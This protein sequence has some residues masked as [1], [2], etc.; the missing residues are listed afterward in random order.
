MKEGLLHYRS[1]GTWL[2]AV[3]KSL[4]FDNENSLDY[5]VYIT[6][7]AVYNAPARA[8]EM[9]SVP[10]R[11]GAFP[12]DQGRFENISV[13]Y[14]AGAFGETQT[15]FASNIMRFRNV[16][17]S[18][19]RYVRL[20]DD[21]NTDE[22][23]LGMYRSGL[24]TKPV[25]MSRAGEFDITFDCKPQRFL[26]SGETPQT[27]SDW[28]DVETETG[29]IVTIDADEKTG[30]KDL[31][32]DIEPIQ[33]LH[34]YTKPWA[35]GNGKN[36]LPQTR[37]T[38]TVNGVTF[39][40]NSDGSVTANGT[41][42][43]GGASFYPDVNTNTSIDNGDYIVTGCPTGGGN[44]TYRIWCDNRNSAGTSTISTTNDAGSG[45][46]LSV[47]E[48]KIRFYIF[49]TAGYTANNLVFKPMFRLASETDASYEPYSN[50]CPI[51]GHTDVVV[52]R[53]G[54]NLL[55]P[56]LLINASLNTASGIITPGTSN[57]V[58]VNKMH[59]P[60]N[61]QLTVSVQSPYQ[62]GSACVYD[63]SGNYLQ[64]IVLSAW[65]DGSYTFSIPN[66]AYYFATNF[67]KSDNANISPSDLDVQIEYGLTATTYE[68]YNGDTYTTALG[69]TVYGGTLDDTTGVLTID[70]AIVTYDGSDDEVWTYYS[71]AQGNMFRIWQNDREQGELNAV[72]AISNRFKLVANADRTNGTMSSPANNP[73]TT[74]IDFIYDACTTEAQWRTWLGSNN[75]QVVYPLATPTTVQLTAEE[76]DLLLGQNNIWASSGDVTVEYGE[77]PFT[78]PTLFASN[79]LI[80]VTGIGTLTVGDTSIV[81]TGTASQVVYIDCESKEIYKINGGVITPAGSLVSF[82]TPDFPQLKPGINK[83]VKGTGITDVEITPRWWRI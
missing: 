78:N 13:K 7:E 64:T 69:T 52:S 36:K 37:T 83:V 22:F 82:S 38:Q 72:G 5:G 29:D 2:M 4:T 26:V 76:I 31:T 68:A 23:R 6:G 70:K 80:K 21:Y 39:T 9:V 74:I 1:R 25:S 71:V 32:A 46:N 40:V 8:M 10:G 67:R 30:L 62:I 45:A 65:T 35:P 58:V 79:P 12:L 81:I 75:V 28:S 16:L 50:I 34:G 47:T 49:I 55:D 56:T 63:G 61:T 41:A 18:R 73:T 66:G 11:N 15:E 43:S 48:G 33:D 42:G 60:P 27:A 44:Q 19:Y 53:T 24:E 59:I 14:P 77:P 3:F 20:S 51:S 57:R 17:A 54:K